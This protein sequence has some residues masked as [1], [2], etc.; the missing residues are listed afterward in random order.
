MKAPE[1]GTLGDIPSLL[2][3]YA[4][5]ELTPTTVVRAVHARIEHDPD[6]IW[7]YKLPL[8]ALTAYARA[9]ETRAKDMAALPLYGIPFAIKDNIDLGRG[10]DHSGMPSVFLYAVVQFN[11]R[12]EINR[13]RRDPHWQDES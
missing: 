12:A 10:T 2:Q 6:H 5:G 4:S 1:S 11:S 9:L 13:C 3:R 7:I 8:E